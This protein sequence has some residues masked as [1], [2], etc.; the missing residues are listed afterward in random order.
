MGSRKIYEISLDDLS[1]LIKQ[2][3]SHID[4]SGATIVDLRIRSVG[5]PFGT[6]PP[7]WLCPVSVQA[8]VEWPDSETEQEGSGHDTPDEAELATK[9][10][11][12]VVDELDRRGVLL[13]RP[14]YISMTPTFMGNS[15]ITEDDWA[16]VRAWQEREG[17]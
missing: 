7:T 11:H 15:I 4:F 17:E 13:P 16:K 14:P 10:A 1:V 3:E 9:V 12:A 5:M 6:D 2:H 8:V